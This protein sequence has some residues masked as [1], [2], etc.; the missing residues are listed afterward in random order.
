MQWLQ[1]LKHELKE[2]YEFVLFLLL[3]FN[4]ITNQHVLLSN[5]VDSPIYSETMAGHGKV[6]NYISEIL[7]GL[8][9]MP[10]VSQGYEMYC[11]DLEV[12][13][14]NLSRVKPGV[15]STSV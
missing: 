13:G 14:S 7:E 9:V 5:P 12:M 1:W 10:K 6:N 3:W 15:H 4:F 8:E 2:P 11:H